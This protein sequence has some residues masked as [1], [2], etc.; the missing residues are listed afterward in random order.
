MDADI[1]I[2]P[3]KE[4]M[5][6]DMAELM[7]KAIPGNGIIQG[8]NISVASGAL[9]ITAG[10]L[11]IGGRLGVVV[12]DST[13]EIPSSITG[14]GRATC[15]LAA[16]CD[17]QAPSAPFF[18]RIY[19]AS[20]FEAL[21]TAASDSETFNVENGQG[22]IH[23]GDVV[24]DLVNRV[25]ISFTANPSAKSIGS[26]AG[27]EELRRSIASTDQSLLN[28]EISNDKAIAD[29]S[30]ELVSWINY[31]RKRVHASSKNRTYSNV[32]S[33]VV[34]PAGVTRTFNVR[35]EYDAE[36]IVE[37]GS[38]GGSV[39]PSDKAYLIMSTNG[40]IVTE[41]GSQDATP[42][43]PVDKYGVPTDIDTRLVAVGI[44]GINIANAS[45]GGANA[46]NC[47]IQSFGIS[48]DHAYVSVRNNGTAQAVLKIG[49]R[50][51]YSQRE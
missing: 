8:C 30:G 50:I 10:R 13:I 35:K 1:R 47:T 15:Y 40:N 36:T 12:E 9:K 29:L 46:A 34:V 43:S 28:Y 3:D 23:L 5:A 27:I 14:T 22:Y 39:L 11:V 16:V 33:G 18:I 7:K 21:E 26:E 2:Y 51:E 20:E 49:I 24:V 44:G 32:F 19:T 25:V 45:S 38:G 37:T 6:L 41:A 42:S 31:L 48:G 4:M 17:L